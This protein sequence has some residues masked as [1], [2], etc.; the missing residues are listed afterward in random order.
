MSTTQLV[1]VSSAESLLAAAAAVDAGLLDRPRRR[2]L[3]LFG[4]APAPE[5]APLPHERP[6][7]S[8]ATARFDDVVVLDELVRPADP[9]RWSPRGDD[10]PVLARLLRQAWGIGDDTVELV[11]DRP[12][13]EQPVEWLMSA[14][15]GCEVVRLVTDIAGYGPAREPIGWPQ[16]RRTS[17]HLYREHVAGLAP[18]P[19]GDE[20]RAG[21]GVAAVA[22]PADAVGKLAQD[23]ASAADLPVPAEGVALVLAESFVAGGILTRDQETALWRDAVRTAAAV[24]GVTEV[25]VLADPV[26]PANLAVRL[27]D[28]APEGVRLTP[29]EQP[30]LAEVYLAAVRPV[31]VVGTMS[32]ALLRARA[33]GVPVV[34]VGAKTVKERLRPYANP[35][36]LPWAVVDAAL[37][38]DGRWSDT[39]DLAHLIGAVAFCMYPERLAERRTEVAAFLDR[40][41]PAEIG[42]YTTANRAQKLGLLPV[43]EPEPA[44]EPALEPTPEPTPEPEPEAPAPA[45]GEKWFRGLVRKSH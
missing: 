10:R 3:V 8:A 1:L 9:G 7:M 38:E 42:R 33:D 41:E 22:I 13:S 16:A 31:V 45:R 44:P 40:L 27:G 20:H 12:Q 36:R 11:C 18:W 21:Q 30:A 25:L 2:V 6:G 15:Y 43:P 32:P 35:A 14:F 34:A 37:R 39:G 5:T 26:V 17:R 19:D 24:D 4:R 28:L 29:V 23:V